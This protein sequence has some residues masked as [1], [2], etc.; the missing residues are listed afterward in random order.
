[1]CSDW[2]EYE[3]GFQLDDQCKFYLCHIDPPFTRLTLIRPADGY[4]HPYIDR[5]LDQPQPIPFH[6]SAVTLESRPAHYSVE[7]PCPLTVCNCITRFHYNPSRTLGRAPSAL[8]HTTRQLA[9]E[10]S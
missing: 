6:P 1:M 2:F 10:M 4:L 5:R 7:R 9:N 8:I 3:S